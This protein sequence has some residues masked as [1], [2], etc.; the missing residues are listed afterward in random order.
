MRGQR[1]RVDIYELMIATA[2]IRDLIL[3]RGSTNEISR[4]A[5][6]QGMICLKDD[7][8]LKAAQGITTVEEVLRTVV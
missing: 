7:G 8:L 4:A 3:R 1:G 6:D 2:E 5:S